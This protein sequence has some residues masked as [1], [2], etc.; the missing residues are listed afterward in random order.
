[1]K[2]NVYCFYKIQI[3]RAYSYLNEEG[4]FRDA[5][6]RSTLTVDGGRLA[7]IVGKDLTS[8]AFQDIT[9]ADNVITINKFDPM[10][11]DTEQIVI[12]ILEEKETDDE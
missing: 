2:F 11:G 3:D 6:T 1:M 12:T 10:E 9:V 4:E 7:D 8:D 5:H